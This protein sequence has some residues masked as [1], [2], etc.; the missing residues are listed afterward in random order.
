MVAGENLF[1]VDKQVGK[2]QLVIFGGVEQLLFRKK[3]AMPLLLPT[4]ISPFLQT[5]IPQPM[6][7]PGRGRAV[8][9]STTLNKFWSG[10]KKVMPLSPVITNWFS[11]D[12]VS[13]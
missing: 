7:M 9:N 5:R 10:S 3:V 11:V 2:I 1:I 4:N 12:N 6:F 13:S 8:P